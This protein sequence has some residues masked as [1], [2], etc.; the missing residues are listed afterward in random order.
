[1]RIAQVA[2]VIYATPPT[3]AGGTERV[4][5]DLTD[6]LVAR[7]HTVTLFAAEGSETRADLIACGPPV[8]HSRDVPPGYAAARE[9]RLLGEVARR[10]DA[11][12]LVH[13]HTEFAHAAVMTG[14]SMPSLTTIHWRVDEAD[15]QDFL[16]A[17]PELPVAAIS[18]AQADA[19][20]PAANIKGVVHHGIP[21]D[22]Y[23]LGDG[24]HGDVAFLGRLT[25]QKGPD[26][27]IRAAQSAE[28]PIRL[29]GNRDIGNP[30]YFAREV[31]PLLGD[32]ARY[33]GP[34]DD[35][36]KQAF[37]GSAGVLCFPIDWPEPF[38]LVVIEAMACGTPVVATAAGASA[39]LIEDGISGYVVSDPADL[40]DALRAAL[41]LDRDRVRAAFERRFSADRMADGYLEIYGRLIG[42]AA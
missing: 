13:F 39:E 9:A 16:T 40:P 12:D 25:D 4:V 34:V 6:T 7:G 36:Q 31:E 8:A 24:A 11:F 30:A 33:V 18:Q 17:F 20:P 5:A 41:K 27:A 28:L 42:A 23:R 22:R 29:A 19:M 35:R 10:L 37:L 32:R 14:R 3:L 21:L 1:M 26:R 15:R 38:G 2:P